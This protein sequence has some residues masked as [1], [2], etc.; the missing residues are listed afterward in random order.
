[1]RD[2][3]AADEFGDN[4]DTLKAQAAGLGFVF[5]KDLLPVFSQFFKDGSAY[6][7]A[8][9]QEIAD[10]GT[11]TANVVTGVANAWRELQS[12]F[13]ENFLQNAATLAFF[14]PAVFV[15]AL[16]MSGEKQTHSKK[17]LKALP[18]KSKNFRR[19][20]IISKHLKRNR[21]RQNFP[22]N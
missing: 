5:A 8:N 11:S 7:S 6:L 16:E 14:V 3:A 1:M 4:L 17:T 22:K 10:W 20:V 15:N 9:K 2:A 13:G 18:R 21:Q 19:L 12:A